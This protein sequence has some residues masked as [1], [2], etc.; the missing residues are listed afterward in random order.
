MPK[1]KPESK[2]KTKQPPLAELVDK[3]DLY[4]ASVQEPEAEV[5]FFDR[6][7]KAE[8]DRRPMRLREDFC[9]AAAVCRDWVLSHG[10]RT[11]V[12]VDLDPEPL[13]WGLE[14]L[15]GDL[16]ADPLDRL[17][18]V[19]GDACDAHAAKGGRPVDL[20]AA[21]NFSFWLFKTREALGRYFAAAHANL[22]RRGLI[23]CDMMGGG[24]CYLEEH[25][26]VRHV[27]GAHL[28]VLKQ[29]AH[30]DGKRKKGRTSTFEYIWEQHR[31]NPI[32]ADA[33]F[34]IHFELPDGSR[35]DRAFRY[36]WRF[37][38]IPEVRELLLEAGFD[39][40]HVYWEGSTSDGEG[41]GVFRKRK[42]APSDPSWIAY[43]VGVKR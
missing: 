12:G 33:T 16:D 27:S 17:T 20:I 38:T 28:P 15:M 41:D 3:Y 24:D 36:D 43:V 19:Q 37:W 30:P 29:W 7:Y 11:A 22:D 40:V 9:A 1:S 34:F 5:A 14:H 18:L 26:D 13:A 42:N 25:K 35:I 4:L 31:F 8:F 21:Q 6:V 10:E 2:P 32:T 23:V 39:E